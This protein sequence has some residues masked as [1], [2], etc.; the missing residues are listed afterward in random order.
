MEYFTY[1][2]LVEIY[3]FIWS[4]MNTLFNTL[5]LMFSTIRQIR[6][7]NFRNSELM[8]DNFTHLPL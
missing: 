1:Y 8:T 7:D 5:I 2:F 6:P 4:K 3:L